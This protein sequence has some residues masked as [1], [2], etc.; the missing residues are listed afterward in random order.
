ML[1][2][3]PFVVRN[4]EPTFS[5]SVHRNSRGDFDGEGEASIRPISTPDPYV[6]NGSG[7]VCFKSE[8]QFVLNNSSNT[9]LMVRL[10]LILFFYKSNSTKLYILQGYRFCTF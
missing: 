8:E 1:I 5:C 4:D 3:T 7:M 10:C 9:F 2:Q 6:N